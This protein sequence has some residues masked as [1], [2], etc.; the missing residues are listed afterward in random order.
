MFSRKQCHRQIRL[1]K[2]AKQGLAKYI[3]LNVGKWPEHLLDR[4]GGLE[5]RIGHYML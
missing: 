4:M 1:D 5:I 2:F 3:P